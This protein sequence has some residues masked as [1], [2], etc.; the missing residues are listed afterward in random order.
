MA[1]YANHNQFIYHLIIF[2]VFTLF[3]SIIV[4]HANALV[5]ASYHEAFNNETFFINNLLTLFFFLEGYH[6]PEL[7][8]DLFKLKFNTIFH[9]SFWSQSLALPNDLNQIWTYNPALGQVF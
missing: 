8:L 9:T 2:I 7:S 5:D 3:I 4:L 1:S 6:P